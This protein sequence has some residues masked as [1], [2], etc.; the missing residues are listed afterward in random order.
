MSLPAAV[1]RYGIVGFRWGGT[2]SFEHAIRSPY[3]DA[4]VV[5]YTSMTAT[6]QLAS[7]QTPVLGLYGGNDSRVNATIAPTQAEMARLK[8]YETR[9]IDGAG[10]GFF[11][12]QDGADGANIRASQAEWPRTVGW[13]R[14]KPRGLK[15]YTAS[16]VPC[17]PRGGAGS[18]GPAGHPGLL[19]LTNAAYR[20]ACGSRSAYGR[21][22]GS[23]DGFAGLTSAHTP[24]TPSTAPSHSSILSKVPNPRRKRSWTFYP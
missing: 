7:V 14:Q 12:H 10:H 17:A 5:F 23:S 18:A 2:V 4:C 16:G 6:D 9:I 20:Q 3:L 13:F 21:P 24:P 1:R 8:P 22:G 19:S 11:R 15:R